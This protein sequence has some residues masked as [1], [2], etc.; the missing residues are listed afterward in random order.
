MGKRE[1][2]LLMIRARALRVEILQGRVTRD[3]DAERIRRS[4]QVER[5]IV[6]EHAN[7]LVALRMR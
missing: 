1:R 5:R 7:A 2:H 3:D 6:R 4:E